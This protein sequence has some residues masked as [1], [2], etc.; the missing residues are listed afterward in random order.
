MSEIVIGD[1]ADSFDNDFG[2]GDYPEAFGFVAPANATLTALEAKVHCNTPFI[3]TL[4]VYEDDAGEPGA[5]I[6]SGFVSH[7]AIASGFD[8]VS[9]GGL[10]APLVAGTT[11]HLAI[12]S[13]A[14]AAITYV[15]GEGISEWDSD[16]SQSGLDDPYPS[17]RTA[18]EVA[19][20]GIRGV[21]VLTGPTSVADGMEWHV[22]GIWKPGDTAVPY[23]GRL[24]RR[25]GGKV[26]IPQGD[27]RTAQLTVSTRDPVMGRIGALVQIPYAVCLKVF[28]EGRLEFWGP[29]KVRTVSMAAGTVTFDAVDMTLR[30][31]NHFLRRGDHLADDDTFTSANQDEGHLPV[32]HEG[33]RILR[34]AADTASFPTL[35]IIDGENDFTPDPTAFIGVQR[36]DEIWQTITE[37]QNAL[38]PDVELQPIDNVPQAY[39]K[40]NTY[41]R[42]GEDRRATVAFG[43]GTGRGRGRLKDLVITEGA[44][45][46]NFV[47]VQ[48][49]SGEHRVIVVNATALARTGPY[50]RWEHTD[51]NAPAGATREDIEAVLTAYGEQILAAYGQP[52]VAA[53]L[54]LF[55]DSRRGYR[56]GKDYGIGD[57]VNV[58][59]V[60]GLVT[61]PALPYR[62]AAVTLNEG[63]DGIVTQEVDV[64]ADRSAGD[65]IDPG[66]P[67]AG[68]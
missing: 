42:Q 33:V 61:V 13:S 65:E 14:S 8:W 56:Y 12:H 45:Y 51:Y 2:I 23:F 44:D 10:S 4:G 19:A 60:S 30:M 16:T 43:Y 32:S 24:T 22:T 9:V 48:D 68:S 6:D 11:Y 49:S 54:T 57:T 34:D 26:Y 20:I 59:G 5:L 28:Y 1:T 17:P 35:G 52:T 37:I 31:K 36:S 64:V 62:V 21:G 38:G 29:C 63:A 7:A 66:D 53:K 40:L 25:S 58:G 46:C 55:P 50:I 15:G 67:E 47:V 18:Y 41:T 27:S 39:A 3:L